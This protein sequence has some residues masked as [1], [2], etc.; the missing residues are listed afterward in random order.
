MAYQIDIECISKKDLL[1]KYPTLYFSAEGKWFAIMTTDEKVCGLTLKV[2][3]Q[4]HSLLNHFQK[5]TLV[6]TKVSLKNKI[7]C[8]LAGTPFQH[9]VWKAL[10]QIPPGT[11]ISYQELARHLQCPKAI[12]AVANAVGANPISPLLPCHRVVGTNGYFGGYF[13]GLPA[14]LTLLREEG[15]DLSSFKGIN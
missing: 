14:K 15:A 12:R 9:Q 1:E 10:L 3:P 2:F 13:W 5:H 8:L 7:P 11:T 4:F 6:E